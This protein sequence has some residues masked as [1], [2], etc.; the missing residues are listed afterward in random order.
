RDFRLNKKKDLDLVVCR[1]PSSSG[2]DLKARTFSSVGD[3][4]KIVLTAAEQRRLR[5][6]PAIREALAGN[7]LIALEAKAAMTS[8]V[9]A[10]PRLF[11]ELNSS[12]QI[13]HGDTGVAIAAG[14]VLVNFATHFISPDSNK[15]DLS[16]HRP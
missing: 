11:D 16:E 7:V 5:N 2:A 8:H 4:Y 3:Q 6:L 1:Y 9:K 13:V 14:L 15:T 12:H 10:C